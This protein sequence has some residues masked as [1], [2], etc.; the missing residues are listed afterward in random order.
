MST[1]VTSTVM[2]IKH[3]STCELMRR[4]YYS[5]IQLEICIPAAAWCIGNSDCCANKLTSDLLCM[6]KEYSRT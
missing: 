4:E 6:R 1:T 2:P 3:V 5:L